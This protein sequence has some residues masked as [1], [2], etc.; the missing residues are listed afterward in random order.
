MPN[1]CSN[2][3]TINHGDKEK[4]DAIEAELNKEKDD[5]ALF[6]MCIIWIL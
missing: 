2:V 4:I 5:V 3:A 1:W 6:Q